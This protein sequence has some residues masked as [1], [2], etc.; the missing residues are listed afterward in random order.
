MTV[1]DWFENG[2]NY[3]DGVALYSCLPNHNKNL[4]TVFFRKE[5]PQNR[6]KLKY[7]LQKN[8][9]PTIG[10]AENFELTKTPKKNIQINIDAAPKSKPTENKFFR[11]LLINQLPIE[12]HPFYIRQKFDYTTYCSLKMQL[13]EINAVKDQFGNVILD[14][15]AKPKIKPQTDLDIEKARVICL[16]IETLFD[17]IDKT[18]Q[19]IDHYLETKEVVILQEKTFENINGVDVYKKLN[20]V[21]GSITRQ[22]TRH[23]ILTKNLEA[24]IAKKFVIKYER[25]LAKC[26]AK[27]MQLNQDK[28]KLI[29]LRDNEK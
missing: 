3:K 6:M 15:D 21:R 1:N 4:A 16:K 10:I 11:K 18:W 22:T 23:K 2:C 8:R 9:T 28:I 5:T 13:N 7:E 24:A 19:I 17:S 26:T 20:S 27:L 14:R 12:L 29:N 25:D